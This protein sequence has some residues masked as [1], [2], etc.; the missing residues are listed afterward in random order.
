M[1]APAVAM[2]SRGFTPFMRPL[3]AAASC[4]PPPV[5][6]SSSDGSGPQQPPALPLPQPPQQQQQQQMPQQQQQ[7][8]MQMQQQQQQQQQ[9]M[10]MQMQQQ[11]QQQLM[12]Q[13]Q[14]QMKQQMQQ[15]LQ[16][17]QLQ[18]PPLPGTQYARA[19]AC[20]YS[21]SI[22][23]PTMALDSP[24]DSP[25]PSLE[26]SVASGMTAA[27][28][29]VANGYQYGA[30]C[31]VYNGTPIAAASSQRSHSP[32]TDSSASFRSI[33]GVVGGRSL[34]QTSQ[35]AVVMAVLDYSAP[36]AR[37]DSGQSMRP[38]GPVDACNGGGCG[39]G[40]AGGAP[41]KSTDALS[42]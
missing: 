27:P 18:M 15:Q 20:D 25:S 35:S 32:C 28:P 19:H 39:F 34:D 16:M 26:S 40:S 3:A 23:P 36:G 6:P 31:G 29:D 30:A 12:K 8:Q 41:M 22:S 21:G 38:T 14:Q 11:Q 37:S 4:P 24:L 33:P 13:M 17:Q 9:Q 7:Q 1:M 5:P 10:Q 42:S 2:P